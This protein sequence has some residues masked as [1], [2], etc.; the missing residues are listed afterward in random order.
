MIETIQEIISTVAGAIV[1][2]FEA[3]VGSI[4]GGAAET[5]DA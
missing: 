2:V 3:I 1:S 4:Q 5:P